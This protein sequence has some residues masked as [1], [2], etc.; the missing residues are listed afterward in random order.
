MIPV[1]L[2]RFTDSQ[3]Q[4]VCRAAKPIHPADRSDFLHAIVKAAPLSV[5]HWEYRSRLP[6]L[7]PAALT[8]G[9][10]NAVRAAFKAGVTPTRIAR[11]FGLSQSDVRKALESKT[12]GQREAIEPEV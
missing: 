11:K 9:Q 1:R 3:I 10:L 12:F 2:P 5:D 6:A 7:P 4:A 8:R